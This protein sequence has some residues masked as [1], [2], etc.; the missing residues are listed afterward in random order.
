MAHHTDFD[1]IAFAYDHLKRLVF[2]KALDKAQIALIPYI[3]S[4]A[5]ILII[6]G[7]TGQIITDILE[8]KPVKQITYVEL[9]AKMLQA[10]KNRVS[11]RKIDNV[12]FFRGTADFLKEQSAFDVIITPFVLDL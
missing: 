4:Q 7:G 2:G 10:A 11:S 6:G 3:P 5:R 12:Q 1:T 8:R 9:S